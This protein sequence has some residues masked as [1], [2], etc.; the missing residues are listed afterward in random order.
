MLLNTFDSLDKN[1]SSFIDIKG[2]P[3]IPSLEELVKTLNCNSGL[4]AYREFVWS[5]KKDALTFPNLKKKMET[6]I[7]ETY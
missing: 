3:K 5:C 4:N 6:D 7:I 2:R 1:L